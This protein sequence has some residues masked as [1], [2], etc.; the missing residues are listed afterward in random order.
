MSRGLTHRLPRRYP[1]AMAPIVDFTD[2]AAGTRGTPYRRGRGAKG[3]EQEL[4][5]GALPYQPA[6]AMTLACPNCDSLSR[7]SSSFC[8][9]CGFLLDSSHHAYV[10]SDA[11]GQATCPADGA[12]TEMDSLVCPA[13][14]HILPETAFHSDD[15]QA[16]GSA[17]FPKDTGPPVEPSSSSGRR[18]LD[19]TS[20][21]GRKTFLDSVHDVGRFVPHHDTFLARLA[22]AERVAEL[23][24]ADLEQAT[25][26]LRWAAS[27]APVLAS[28]R[29][30]SP[31]MR[32][33]FV[34]MQ[35][36]ETGHARAMAAYQAAR[37]NLASMAGQY[38]QV[39]PQPMP[40][41]DWD[42]LS[43]TDRSRRI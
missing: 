11:P 21:A 40:S 32:H 6:A 26:H 29:H 41:G 24:E 20:A 19:D 23:C 17:P 2:P 5:D 36:A 27:E 10:A 42:G 12:R 43:P 22:E 4:A 33:R 13:C 18:P 35:E 9:I 3:Q 39:M 14:G 38:A 1:L 28:E 15:G 25:F 7:P 16:I 34:V 31:D 37:R 30:L 8:R